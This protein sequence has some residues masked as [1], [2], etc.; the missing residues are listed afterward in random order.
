MTENRTETFPKANMYISIENKQLDKRTNRLQQQQQ[1]KNDNEFIFLGL[2]NRFFFRHFYQRFYFSLLSLFLLS[3]LNFVVNIIIDV[4][5]LHHMQ[6]F[7]YI[8]FLL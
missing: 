1:R 7:M 3:I 2:Q 4:D 6:C 5:F 8:V